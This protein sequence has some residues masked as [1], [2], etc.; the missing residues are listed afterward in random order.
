MDALIQSFSM[1]AIAEIGDKTQLLSILL[2]ARFRS[3]WPIIM[4]V[5]VATLINHALVAW[6]GSHMASM[7][8]ADWIQLATSLL[9]IAVA[10]W[11]LIPDKEP[12]VKT[13]SSNGAFIT[14]CIAFF[15]AEMGDKTQLATLTLGAQYSNTVM[16]ILGTTIGMLAA[17]IPAVLF[18]ETLLKKIPLKMVRV[19]AC[20][21]FLAFGITGLIGWYAS[22]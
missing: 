5:L 9:F 10:F 4:G 12:D 6:L 3:F 22:S 8:S 13:G 2:A 18:G 16:V 1:V 7:V 11:T 17:N 19:I 14:S 15:I 20:M 21:I